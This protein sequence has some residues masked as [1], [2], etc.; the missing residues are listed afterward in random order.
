MGR[1]LAQ[2]STPSSRMNDCFGSMR[3]VPGCFALAL[4]L[5]FGEPGAAAEAVNQKA[6]TT[7]SIL[8]ASNPGDW[9]PLDPENTLYVEL[10]AGRVVIELAPDFA[11]RHV[12]NV[13]ALAREHYYDGLAIVRCQDNY[14]V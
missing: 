1:R 13:K 3:R 7:A 4:L 5:F 9:R 14:V 11:P 6:V 8:A 10:P 2:L 12:A